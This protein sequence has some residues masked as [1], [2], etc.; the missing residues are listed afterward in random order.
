M[1][2]CPCSVASDES[3]DFKPEESPQ[4]LTF[5]APAAYSRLDLCLSQVYPDFSRSRWQQLIEQGYIKVNG[6]VTNLKKIAIKIGDL[7]E[8]DLPPPQAS[9]LVPETIPLDILFEDDQLIVLNKPVGLVV[10]PGPGHYAGTLVHA[11][12]AHCPDLPGI[13]GEQRPG[14]VHRLDKDTS[15]VMMVAKTEFALHQLQAQIKARTAKRDYLG[16]VQGVP[17]GINGTINAPIGRHP[18]ERKK[19]AVTEPGLGREAITHWSIQ[20]RL[21]HYTLVHFQL[22]TGRTHQIR[23]HAANSGWPIVGDPVYGTRQKVAG[24]VLAGQQLHG[25]Q[26]S[27]VHPITQARLRFTAPLPSPMEQLL[28]ALRRRQ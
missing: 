21:G 19:M 9:V 27:L 4:A 11:L 5:Q 15:G 13:G 2:S 28:Q 25:W 24:K 8:A 18:V 7:I 16:L 17:P 3:L 20:E 12:L 1:C 6:I 10:H 26:L 23:V 14:I 22:E